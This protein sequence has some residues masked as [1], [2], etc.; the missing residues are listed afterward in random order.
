[1]VQT[2]PVCGWQESTKLLKKLP[3]SVLFSKAVPR[4][5]AEQ[6]ILENGAHLQSA[7][8]SILFSR[9]LLK[10]I[11]VAKPKP[12]G[13]GSDGSH[14]AEAVE[15]CIVEEAGTNRQ[16]SFLEGGFFGWNVPESISPSLVLTAWLLTSF[17]AC[18]QMESVFKPGSRRGDKWERKAE[19]H[20]VLAEGSE[21]SC[22]YGMEG[23][24][25]SGTEGSSG[26]TAYH[27]IEMDALGGGLH[28]TVPH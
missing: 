6:Y 28:G 27:S 22:G 3:H 4:H 16:F 1:M 26:I 19:G 5:K 11:G 10:L 18:L 9:L 2:S 13:M 7:L 12:H 21:Q 17:A 23:G 20:G 8:L 14:N 25:N 15:H 24:G